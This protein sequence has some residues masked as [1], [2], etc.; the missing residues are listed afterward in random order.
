MALDLGW[1]Q[2]V[3]T[4][5]Q[6]RSYLDLLRPSLFTPRSRHPKDQPHKPK[7]LWYLQSTLHNVKSHKRHETRLHPTHPLLKLG[8]KVCITRP[9]PQIQSPDPTHLHGPGWSLGW[10]WGAHSM[11]VKFLS[12]PAKTRPSWTLT[13]QDHLLR[14]QWAHK[15]FSPGQQGP[16][17]S[18]A[19]MH[20]FLD[21]LL[22]LRL[23]G[24]AGVRRV[25]R[26]ELWPL[27]PFPTGT[28]APS[29]SPSDPGVTL[30]CP[31]CQTSPTPCNLEPCKAGE[32]FQYSP[33]LHLTIICPHPRPSP[34]LS[35]PHSGL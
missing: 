23:W 25:P 29:T 22:V 1:D 35:E 2:H 20:R 8:F 3:P 9:F 17:K 28:S 34:T 6:G 21:L 24:D 26:Q 19:C 7:S 12:N 11:S 18:A 13:C 27:P 14:G 10:V 16:K 4:G 31:L 5:R 32:N 33:G 15:Q 30:P